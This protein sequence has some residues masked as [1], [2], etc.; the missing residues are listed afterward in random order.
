MK[1]VSEENKKF[2]FSDALKG[3]VKNQL[4][5]PAIY[6][7]NSLLTGENV[8]P[9]HL[10]IGNPRNPIMS[11]GN[12]IMTNSEVTHTGP[13]GIDDFPTEIIV[14]VTLKHAR[15]RDSVEIQKMYTKG[16][17]SIYRPMNLIDINKFWNNTSAF[18]DIIGSSSLGLREANPRPQTGGSTS[19]TG[20]RDKGTDNLA[21]Q[22]PIDV[23]KRSLASI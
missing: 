8:G 10:T 17:S 16:L 19:A 14:K 13:L 11:I 4:G 15:P 5:R 23:L 7:M 12:L 1:W 21:N 3:M 9:W 20:S 18:P 2:K 22:S 6:A